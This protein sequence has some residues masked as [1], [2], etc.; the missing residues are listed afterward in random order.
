MLLGY[1]FSVP[2]NPFDF[3]PAGFK[4]PP[5]SPL[6]EARAWRARRATKASKKAKTEAD[7]QYYI[8]NAEHPRAK[9]ADFLE[10]AIFSQDLFDS[11]SILSA[12]S[13]E[14]ASEK[15]KSTGTVLGTGANWTCHRN[16]LHTLC[17][18]RIEC[19]SKAKAIRANEFEL[20]DS[21]KCMSTQKQRYAKLYRD[22]QTLILDT[23][24][25]LCK[26]C[27]LRAQKNCQALTES[28]LSATAA[29]GNPQASD[30]ARNVQKLVR[31]TP[32]AI[33]SKVLFN[34]SDAVN[35]LPGTLIPEIHDDIK[36]FRSAM[37]ERALNLPSFDNSTNAYMNEK[38]EF[39]LWLAFLRK[40]YSDRSSDLPN[41]LNSWIEN[42]QTWYPFEDPI[43]NG[44]TEDFLP[45]LEALI[46]AAERITSGKDGPGLHQVWSD[47]T[48]L[49]WGW[50]V[51]EEEGV[52]IDVDAF[53]LQSDMEALGPLK[54]L[55]YIPGL[56]ERDRLPN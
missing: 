54:F 14:L 13:R 41:Q 42:L 30:V 51:Q 43:W 3:F 26:Y 36:V 35:L 48:M 47:P 1:G 39:T 52:L 11:V 10:T 29:E 46:E 21:P 5:G 16:L 2:E 20:E 27:L 15:F 34:F 44:P 53:H 9:A 32:S 50:N 49:S 37:G 56:G 23:A 12:N 19:H 6:A 31:R 7:F 24:T 33:K 17:Q 45:T 22:S 40:I 55:L 4:V 25:F 18:L 38:I 28:G 8:F